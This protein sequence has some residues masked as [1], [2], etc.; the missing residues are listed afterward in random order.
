MRASGFTV[1]MSKT[2]S[3]NYANKTYIMWHAGIFSILVKFLCYA[4][5]ILNALLRRDVYNTRQRTY[6]VYRSHQKKI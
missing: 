6:N 5:H 3:I 1:D 2:L 4:Q